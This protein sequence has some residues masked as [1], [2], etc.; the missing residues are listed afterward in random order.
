MVTWI[1]LVLILYF[2]QIYFAGYFVLAKEGL[3]AHAGPRD[4]I[5]SGG[6]YGG[7]A[8]RALVNMKENL[9]FFFVPAVL[10]LVLTGADMQL[11]VIGAQMFFFARIAYVAFYVAGVPWLRSAA[12]SVALLGNILTVWALWG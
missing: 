3:V 6:L 4:T 11:A 8:E 12:Y 7:R 5:P 10:A 1:V 9:P 2:V